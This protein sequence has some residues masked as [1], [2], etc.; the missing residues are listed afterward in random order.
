ML[1]K[2]TEFPAPANPGMAMRPAAA[3]AAADG[4]ARGAKAP[5]TFGTERP[6]REGSIDVSLGA[7]TKTGQVS[8]TATRYRLAMAC[9]RGHTLPDSTASPGVIRLHAP[10][11]T[12]A[13]VDTG[14]L[15]AGPATD[16]PGYARM[17]HPFL[18]A[19]SG[20]TRRPEAHAPQLWRP[21]AYQAIKFNLLGTLRP[22][23]R[24]RCLKGTRPKTE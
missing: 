23:S 15:Q 21:L 7:R 4:M 1:T 3:A 22:R 13:L 12:K 5:W 2:R 11:S 9:T 20:G 16:L 10:N 6:A 18:H 14:P 17:R 24:Q 19:C 8:H